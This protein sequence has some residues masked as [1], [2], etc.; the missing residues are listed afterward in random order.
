MQCKKCNSENV[1]IQKVS[2]TKKKKKGLG[3]WLLFGWFI[4]LLLWLFLTIPRLLIAMFVPKKTKTVVH[5]EAVCQ[6]CGYSWKI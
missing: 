3:Y 6:S 1:S 4:D 5:T 2:T